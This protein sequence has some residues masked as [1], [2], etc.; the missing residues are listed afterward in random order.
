MAFQPL[1]TGSFDTHW[2]LNEQK[3]SDCALRLRDGRRLSYAVYGAPDGRPVFYLHGWP[4]SRLEGRLHAAT[5]MQKG[6]CLIA[7]DRP[8][9]GLSD[10]QP[11]RTLL[12]WPQDVLAVA[13]ALGI[14]R[15]LV[16]PASC[17]SASAAA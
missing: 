11:R 5:A 4:S 15:F 12:N 13:T 1:P 6:V 2:E 10:F 17:F 16:T 14:A 8:G 7:I 3:G 9:F